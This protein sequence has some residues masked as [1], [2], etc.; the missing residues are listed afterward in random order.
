M[1]LTCIPFAFLRVLPGQDYKRGNY[2]SMNV[3]LEFGKAVGW[4]SEDFNCAPP[5]LSTAPHIVVTGKIQTKDK[6][7]F[8]V[9]ENP[10]SS[11]AGLVIVF[12]NFSFIILSSVWQGPCQKVLFWTKI[13]AP[14]SPQPFK[15]AVYFID[16][17]SSLFAEKQRSIWI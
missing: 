12:L 8:F 5:E 7:G 4:I 10:V 17:L 9:M 6:A 11:F 14:G 1:T 13:S 16:V 3:G 2:Q 15:L